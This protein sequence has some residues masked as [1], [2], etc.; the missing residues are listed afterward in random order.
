MLKL[1]SKL[2]TFKF[3]PTSLLTKACNTAAQQRIKGNKF[4]TVEPAGCS[5][6]AAELLLQPRTLLNVFVRD[7]RFAKSRLD[8]LVAPPTQE[9]AMNSLTLF[10]ALLAC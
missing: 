2:M 8:G 4:A 6:S 7:V 3:N 5:G 10:S 9:V 1:V